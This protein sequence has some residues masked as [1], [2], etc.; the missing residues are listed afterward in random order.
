MD[1]R[2]QRHA[3]RY[4]IPVVRA[5]GFT[6]I[7]ILVALVVLSVGLLGIAALYVESLRASRVSFNRMT[8][9][10]LAS[11]MADRIRANPAAGVAY[12]GAGPG[13]DNGCVNGIAD[14]TPVQ[15]AQEDWFT[16][17]QDVAARLPGEPT[18]NINVV[19]VPPLTRYTIRLNWPETGQPEAAEY[20]LVTQ[21]ATP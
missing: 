5:S 20:V 16:W 4:P 19:A 14:C 10:T 2:R 15:L 8:A 13:A 7:E 6:L 18:A 9:V 1:T 11:D 21:E 17:S 3:E 12:A